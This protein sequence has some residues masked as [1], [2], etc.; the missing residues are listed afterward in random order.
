MPTSADQFQKLYP[1]VFGWITATL[2]A[3]AANAR[4]VGSQNFPRLPLYFGRDVLASAKFVVA[5]RL[6][7]PPL[8]SIGLTQFADFERAEFDAITYLDTFFIRA[9]RANDEGLYFHE[10]THV[11]QWKILGPERFLLDYATGLETRGYRDSPLEAMA[12]EAEQRFRIG[13]SFN[14]EQLVARRLQET[15]C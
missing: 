7:M 1:V 11:I 5:D 6:P 9:H 15:S 4:T 14:A 3:S 2:A 8:S 13:E 12:Y 10:L